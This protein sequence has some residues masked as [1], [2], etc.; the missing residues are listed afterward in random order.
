VTTSNPSPQKTMVASYER[1][2]MPF[3]FDALIST[4]FVPFGGVQKLRTDAIDRMDVQPD[5]SVLELACGTGGITKL[6]LARGAQVT[7]IDGAEQMLARARKRAPG[8]TY[9]QSPLEDFRPATRYDFVLLAFVLHEIPKDLRARVLNSAREAL[10]PGGTVV[11]LDHAVPKSGL[12][13][14]AWRLFLLKLEP[15]TVRDCIE[16]GY[17]AELES[18]G[19]NV[20]A[21]HALAGG[22]A[23]LTLARAAN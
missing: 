7:A 5:A 16:A 14:R 11:V 8:A 4:L 18:A 15:P 3:V 9:Q 1:S 21:H 13:S 23:E 10:A 6:L 2:F 19:L 12:F 22:T 17:D 20:T